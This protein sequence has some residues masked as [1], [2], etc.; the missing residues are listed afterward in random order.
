MSDDSKRGK[1]NIPSSSSPTTTTI[2]TT[3]TTRM[4]TTTRTRTKTA[5]TTTKTTNLPLPLFRFLACVFHQMGGVVSGSALL[6][7]MLSWKRIGNYSAELPTETSGKSGFPKE[8]TT[9]RQKLL[10]INGSKNSKAKTRNERN[11][12][13]VHAE[14]R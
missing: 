6:I 4:A 1:G 5:T 3:T 7:T 13:H 14:H 10:R 11:I 9:P 2:S 8:E 12:W